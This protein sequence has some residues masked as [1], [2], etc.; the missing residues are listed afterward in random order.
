MDEVT[1]MQQQYLQNLREEEEKELADNANL[2]KCFIEFS[3]SK[4]V[5]LTDDNFKY[6][7]TIGIVACFPNIVAK[8]CP[9][10]VKDKEGL[11]N[12]NDLIEKFER[13]PQIKGYLY[14]DNFML[15]AHPYFRR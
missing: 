13:R 7:Q 1:E 8:I 3:A 9:N 4:G 11:L 10:V 6:L 12:F 14:A 15:M 2:I 5:V